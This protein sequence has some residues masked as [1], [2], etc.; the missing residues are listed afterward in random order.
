MYYG[1]MPDFYCSDSYGYRQNNCA[2]LENSDRVRGCFVIIDV[3]INIYIIFGS[4]RYFLDVGKNKHA[5]APLYI[6]RSCMRY[7]I[8]LAVFSNQTLSSKDVCTYTHNHSGVHDTLLPCDVYRVHYTL[9]TA[10][11]L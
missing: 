6:N 4:A 1:R 10:R 2:Y 7:R 11:L 9:F 8:D 3:F 5:I